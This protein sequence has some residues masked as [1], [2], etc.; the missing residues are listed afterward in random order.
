MALQRKTLN[1][2]GGAARCLFPSFCCFIVHY[3][4]FF[5]TSFAISSVL[6]N[7]SLTHCNAMVFFAPT[8]SGLAPHGLL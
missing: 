8:F 1:I 2:F 5:Y 7:H 4:D 6:R 3:T